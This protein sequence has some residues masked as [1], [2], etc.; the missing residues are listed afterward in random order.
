MSLVYRYISPEHVPVQYGG[1]SVDNCDCNSDFTHD[2]IATEI[3]IKPTTKQTVEIIIYEVRPSFVFDKPSMD[4]L[5][6]MYGHF[7]QWFDKP[8][9]VFA[10]NT[11]FSR[12]S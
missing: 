6:T 10:I 2:D 11:K 5:R 7:I 12:F 8:S 4:I 9:F 1:L 3:T